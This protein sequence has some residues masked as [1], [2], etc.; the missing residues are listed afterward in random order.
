MRQQEVR[1]KVKKAKGKV[2]QAVGI[3]SGDKKMEH[4]GSLQRAQGAIEEGFSKA[5]DKI[6]SVFTN[7][8][9]AISK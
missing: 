6:G 4:E 5:Y 8:G 3:L 9:K 2:K 1:G 7:I